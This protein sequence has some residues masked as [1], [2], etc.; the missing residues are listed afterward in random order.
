[1]GKGL[2]EGFKILDFFS[3]RF[4]LAGIDSAEAGEVCSGKV[5]I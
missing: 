3:G 4:F 1:M 2:V 5:N